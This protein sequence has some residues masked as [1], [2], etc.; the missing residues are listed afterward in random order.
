MSREKALVRHRYACFIFRINFAHNVPSVV[1]LK[2]L[3]NKLEYKVES[4]FPLQYHVVFNDIMTSIYRSKIGKTF[5]DII[6]HH[7]QQL[8]ECGNGKAVKIMVLAADSKVE[9]QEKLFERERRRLAA[10]TSDRKQ[11]NNTNEAITIKTDTKSPTNWTK[12]IKDRSNRDEYLKFFQQFVSHSLHKVVHRLPY[13]LIIDFGDGKP[14][15]VQTDEKQT[16]TSKMTTWENTI[17]EG[18]LKV[19]SFYNTMAKDK[20]AKEANVMIISDDTD[21]VYATLLHNNQLYQNT[22]IYR[23]KSHTHVNITSVRQEIEKKMNTNGLFNSIHLCVATMRC[24]GSDYV[25]RPNIS[26]SEVLN[27]VTN[28]KQ[29]EW[30]HKN[31][32]RISSE[33]SVNIQFVDAIMSLSM[34]RKLSRRSSV[35]KGQEATTMTLD[36]L[37]QKIQQEGRK[38]F[39]EEEVPAGLVQHTTLLNWDLAYLRLLDPQLVQIKAYK[40]SKSFHRRYL[41]F[42]PSH[43]FNCLISTV[44]GVVFREVA[45]DLWLSPYGV[46]WKKKQK[47][48]AYEMVLRTKHEEAPYRNACRCNCKVKGCRRRNNPQCRCALQGG[49]LPTCGCKLGNASEGGEGGEGESDAMVE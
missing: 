8:L 9:V 32:G 30:I 24:L 3:F 18:E 7:L 5:G 6:H 20:L 45:V 2:Q 33:V 14:L 41:D 10:A 26:V 34:W 25:P 36:A 40:Q 11:K 13:V 43:S 31:G 28:T 1:A 29:M 46:T 48:N 4:G 44:N 19:I 35:C 23:P 38:I 16:T 37:S 49:C 27:T 12:W 15:M 21:A 39:H 22:Y 47:E 42:T 17:P